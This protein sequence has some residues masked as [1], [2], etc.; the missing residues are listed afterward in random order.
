M[1]D[2]IAFATA[3]G[4]TVKG[5]P[6]IHEFELIG[7]S[8][9]RTITMAQGS[10]LHPR[11]GG[12]LFH[13]RLTFEPFACEPSWMLTPQGATKWAA[14]SPSPCAPED[15]P[16]F[17]TFGPA[18][19]EFGAEVKTHWQL[20]RGEMNRLYLEALE[21]VTPRAWALAWAVLDAVSRAHE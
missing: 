1:N 6:T 11:G 5:T 18:L 3:H 9:G 4:L 14:H 19:T 15:V 8:N 7:A 2:L 10:I 13:F 21:L 16:G 20:K 17:A 12:K